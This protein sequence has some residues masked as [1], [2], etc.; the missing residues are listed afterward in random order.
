M[1]YA[2]VSDITDRYDD[3]FLYVIADDDNDDALD[4]DKIESALA[5][6]SSLID[7][8][9][10]KRYSLPLNSTPD[11]LKR[12]CINI[13]IYS[14]GEDVA[15]AT[16][17]SRQ[18]YEDSIGWLKLFAEGKTDLPNYETTEESDEQTNTSGAFFQS[19]ER[20]FSRQKLGG[21]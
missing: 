21:F 9:L 4:I 14:L 6:A 7:S 8:Y 11:L 1:A 13:A 16:E 15:S 18:R 2:E 12:H 3:D 5:D 20:L 19:S 10:S 17:Q